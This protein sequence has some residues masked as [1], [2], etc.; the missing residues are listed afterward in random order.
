[1]NPFV[2]VP[3]YNPAQLKGST[4]ILPMVSIGNVPQ[5][6]ADLLIQTFHFERVGFIDTDT[7]IPVSSQREDNNQIGSTT[8]IEVFQSKDRRWTCIQ[9][10]SPTIKEKRKSYVDHITA[11]A[12][13]FD[14]VIVLTS[15][16]A[17]RRLDSQINSVPFRVLGSGDYVN[18]SKA[19][20]IPILE[21][22]SERIHLPGSGL[23]RH[24]YKQ[25]EDKAT[26]LIMFALEGDNVQDSIDFGNY[27]HR[28][29]ELE[30]ITQFTPPKS[31]E[32]LFGT[33]F[34][35]DL[36]H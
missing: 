8:P 1:M 26:V 33:P 31:W 4:I 13:Q 22:S 23:S 18:R 20:G 25:L 19:L 32:F 24:V 7:V 12:S 15:M 34:N 29:L 21:E 28:V 35:A 9:Q 2:P 3:N 14:Q 10:R 17:S 27:I 11:F 6:T 30:Q 36:Y 16:D 5:L